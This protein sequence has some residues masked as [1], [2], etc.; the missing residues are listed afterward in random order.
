MGQS[1]GARTGVLVATGLWQWRLFDYLEYGDHSRFD[2]LVSQLTQ[3][4]TVKEDK[5]RFRVSVAENIFDENEPVRLDAELYNSSYE[6]INGPEATVVVTGSEGREY[7]YTFTRTA[8][9]YT[10]NAGTLPPGNYRF[11]AVTNDGSGEPL[12]SDG[13]FSVQAVE[14]ERYALEAD[15]ALL[16][17]LSDRYGG[18]LLLPG[19][20]DRLGGLLEA[21]GGVKPL[22]FQTVNTRSVLNLEWLFFLLLALFSGEWVLRRWAGGY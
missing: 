17:Q 22:L 21:S 8:S 14:L 2:E 20:L 5:R 6:L 4:L 16:R 13:R 10:L 7:A 3:Y 18:E 12:V 11:R 15:H 19:Q 1:R 9:A